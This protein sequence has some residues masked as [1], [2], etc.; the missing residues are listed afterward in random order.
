MP[1]VTMVH[2]WKMPLLLLAFHQFHYD[3]GIALLRLP[4]YGHANISG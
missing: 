2:R 4:R 3:F 1:C